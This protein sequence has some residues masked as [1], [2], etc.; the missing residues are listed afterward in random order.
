MCLSLPFQVYSLLDFLASLLEHPRAKVCYYLCIQ[1]F[2]F[3]LPGLLITYEISL[4]ISVAIVGGRCGSD[5]YGS[6]EEVL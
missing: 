4:T 6:A 5:V 2:F 3:S 1:K